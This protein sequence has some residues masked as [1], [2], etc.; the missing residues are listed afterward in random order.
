LHPLLEVRRRAIHSA[1][2]GPLGFD[3]LLE[4]RNPEL[5][6]TSFRR[7]SQ[8]PSTALCAVSHVK[9]L[10][11]WYHKLYA[12][13]HRERNIARSA[14]VRAP[15]GR[16]PPFGRQQVDGPKT[17][18][19]HARHRHA[20]LSNQ[21][22]QGPHREPRLREDGRHSQGDGFPARG[23]VRG[24]AW[25]RDAGRPRG[26][27]EPC[28]QGRASL[29]HGQAPEDGRALHK[30]RG[31]PPSR[32][33]PRLNPNTKDAPTTRHAARVSTPTRRRDR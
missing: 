6:R 30:R 5:R 28:R 26:E 19:G 23:V 11:L 20:L 25:E 1:T 17:R 22:A 12:S 24:R 2:L 33:R 13:R 15:A 31:R 18:R 27:A 3:L 7:S 14:K 8:H 16:P 29:R 32:P 4:L 21:P 10:E 9:L